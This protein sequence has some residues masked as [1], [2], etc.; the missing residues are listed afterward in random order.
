MD[1]IRG[2]LELIEKIIDLDGSL[3]IPMG[4]EE[5]LTVYYDVHDNGYEVII[6]NTH[7]IAFSED[8]S[9]LLDILENI[10]Q[11]YTQHSTILGAIGS[12]GYAVEF[13]EFFCYPEETDHLN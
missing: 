8:L 11:N 10:I 1:E 7:E 4:T 6:D 2:E 3:D 13:P 9:D 12:I 5:T